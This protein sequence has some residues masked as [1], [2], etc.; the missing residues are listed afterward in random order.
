MNKKSMTFEELK[1]EILKYNAKSEHQQASI[2]ILRDIFNK[3]INN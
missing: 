2:V 3:K 1:V